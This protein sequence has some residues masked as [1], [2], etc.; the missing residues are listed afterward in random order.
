[1]GHDP[2]GRRAFKFSLVEIVKEL[3]KH[4]QKESR[5]NKDAYKIIVKFKPETF[6]KNTGEDRPL[7]IS[8][9]TKAYQACSGYAYISKVK[10]G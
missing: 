2:K 1:M 8:F 5:M 4:A 9:K 7:S 10:K 6:L 3:L